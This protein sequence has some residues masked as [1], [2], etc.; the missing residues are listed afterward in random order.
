MLKKIPVVGGVFLCLLFNLAWAKD[1]SS[2]RDAY[3]LKTYIRSAMEHHLALQAAD[4]SVSVSVH[5]QESAQQP[6]YNPELELDSEQTDINTT[7][8]GISQAIDWGGKRRANATEAELETA[9]AI[10]V[11][12]KKRQQLIAQLLR[13]TSN[14]LAAEKLATLQKKRIDSIREFA[15]LA[16]KRLAA[17]DISQAEKQLADLAAAE[18]G[19]GYARAKTDLLNAVA[20]IRGLTGQN[21]P[22][23]LQ[24][25]ALPQLVDIDLETLLTNHPDV[26]LAQAEVNSARA[27]TAV[28]EKQRRADP[29][30]G[31]RA[32]KEESEKLLGLTFSIPLYIRNRFNAELKAAEAEALKAELEAQ[33][34]LRQ[35]R[36]KLAAASA[37]YRVQAEAWKNWQSS[38]VEN[39]QDYLSLIE[40]LWRS[41]ELTTADYLV[42]LQ[43]G[44]SATIAGVE[45][46]NTSRLTWVDW[47]EA[48]GQVAEWL[49]KEEIQ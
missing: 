22:K 20:E 26:R 30:V 5:A 42:Q 34:T 43:Q 32:G 14:W 47:L 39:T 11:R 29:V 12:D 27:A 28:A 18:A 49:D 44:L 23:Q 31:L 35:M 38:G 24:F 8:I 25:P 2:P 7:S 17:G 3:L 21:P 36:E 4:A 19:I 33:L 37:S 13:T 10:A 48:S 41:G 15:E 16:G 46:Q 1:I 45:L 6:L 9:K 40:R